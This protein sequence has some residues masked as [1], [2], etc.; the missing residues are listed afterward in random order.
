MHRVSRLPLVALIITAVVSTSAPAVA[1]G[2]ARSERER[3][4]RERAQVAAELDVLRASGTEVEQALDALDDRAALEAAALAS[5]E[6]ALHVAREQAAA[7]GRREAD[8][9]G[10]IAALEDAVRDAAIADYITGGSRGTLDAFLEADDVDFR[11]LMTMRVLREAVTLR[12]ADVTDELNAAREDHAIARRVAEKAAAE[13]RAA[14]TAADERLLQVRDARAQQAAFASELDHRI[15]AR[16][17]EAANLESVDRDLA[18]RIARE[19]A[20]LARRAPRVGR[21]PATGR[22]PGRVP[23]V[24]VRGITVHAD[25]AENLRDLLAAADADDLSFGGGGYRDPADQQRLREAHC[26]DPESSPAASCHPPTARPGQSM[27]EWGL[28]IDFTLDGRLIQSET[29]PGFRWLATNAGRFGLRNLAGEP[30]HWSTN[31][32]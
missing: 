9:A 19:E 28:A 27:H 15:E 5:A 30:W 7:A 14:R 8:T 13:A 3:V 20:E 11:E 31:G 1:G 4:R 6:Q 29:N 23:L 26:P 22:G 2:D 18:A 25:I 10:Q 21:S 12:V 16:L 17:A 32:S 24:T